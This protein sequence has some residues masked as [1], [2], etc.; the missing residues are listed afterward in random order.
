M[1]LSTDKGHKM[2]YATII[3]AF[4]LAAALATVVYSVVAPTFHHV[5][6]ML[7]Q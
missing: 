6:A 5:A 2:K 1:N 7:A 4:I 3:A